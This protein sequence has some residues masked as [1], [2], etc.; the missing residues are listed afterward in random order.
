MNKIVA[1][2]VTTDANQN[3]EYDDV[4]LEN[5]MSTTELSEDQAKRD[6]KELM[7]M[8]SLYDGVS[9][10]RSHWRVLLAGQ[11]LA[12]FLAASRAIA[13]SLYYDCNI[14]IPTA[15]TALIFLF[16]SFHLIKLIGKS[17]QNSQ[18]KKNRG[19]TRKFFSF[20]RSRED[21]PDEMNP[22]DLALGK[23]VSLDSHEL[24][25]D[26]AYPS[27]QL[28][29]SHSLFRIPLNIPIWIYFCLAFLLVEAT[30]VSSLALK[31]TTLSSASMLDN[32]NIFAAMVASR[33]ILKRRYSWKHI[34]GASICLIGV[35]LNILSDI[36]TNKI[37]E[38]EVNDKSAQLEGI[39]FSNRPLGDFLAIL[40]GVLFGVSDV[41]TE[42]IV[43]NFVEADE[44]LGCIGIFGF[45]I[46]TVQ[47]AVIERGDISKFLSVEEMDMNA[48]KEYENPLE[49]PRT[50]SQRTANLL[51][52][53]YALTGYLFIS[54][55]SR[56][57]TVSETALLMISILTSDLWAV[58]F[59]VVAEHILPHPLFYVSSLLMVFGIIM[60]EMSPSPLG[61]AEDLQIHKEIELAED[62]DPF[63]LSNVSISWDDSVPDPK[64]SK[65]R[66]L[67]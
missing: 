1:P 59:T 54:G 48:Y 25:R 53:C 21:N 30:Y 61:P 36:E 67:V 39:K 56:F 24:R 2:K 35:G 11:V 60:Y 43:K 63:D 41:I 12:F 29:V 47:A 28:T 32:V 6:D 19:R 45:L 66:E 51:F 17:T 16:M 5:S 8:A 57:L 20:G 64:E 3:K 33:I 22:D 49:A 37:E 15:Q 65:Q 38:G 14:S 46:A 52:V 44:F 40:G 55:M 31:Y 13:S 9:R 50:C 62:I 4:S 7:T 34:L 42:N 10:V 23:S 26:D 27:P 58:L 18:K